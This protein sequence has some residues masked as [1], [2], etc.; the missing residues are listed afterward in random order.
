MVHLILGFCFHAPLIQISDFWGK[1]YFGE[2]LSL[3]NVRKPI[4]GTIRPWQFAID[5]V[6][7]E[8]DMGDATIPFLALDTTTALGP[9]QPQPSTKPNPQNNFLIA[10]SGFIP[11]LVRSACRQGGGGGVELGM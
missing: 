2:I 6:F 11:S 7:S 3:T 5:A 8:E 10:I 9:L 4:R 1:Y